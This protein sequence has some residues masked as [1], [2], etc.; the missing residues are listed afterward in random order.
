MSTQISEA[1][2]SRREANRDHQGKFGNDP[3]AETDLILG[4]LEEPTESDAGQE[5]EGFEYARI[6][7]LM[8]DAYHLDPERKVALP[9]INEDDTIAQVHHKLNRYLA[10]TQDVSDLD[11]E[12][13]AEMAGF[14]HAPDEEMPERLRNEFGISE[15]DR[16]VVAETGDGW[17]VYVSTGNTAKKTGSYYSR[18][19]RERFQV[20]NV[21]EVT[22]APKMQQEFADDHPDLASKEVKDLFRR[23]NGDY[24]GKGHR[25]MWNEDALSRRNYFA[26]SVARTQAGLSDTPMSDQ[27]LR[28]WV[29]SLPQAEDG[30]AVVA[31]PRGEA[32]MEAPRGIEGDLAGTSPHASSAATNT[33][34][35]R[36]ITE[37]LADEYDYTLQRKY[38][39]DNSGEGGARVF[40]QK[41]NVPQ[42]HLDAAEASTF[43]TT[44]DF[45]HVEVDADTDL[46]KLAHVGAEYEQLRKHLPKTGSTPTL[47]FRKTGRH[48]ALGV[49]HPHVDNIAVDPRSPSAMIHEYAH[50][51]DHTAGDRNLSS[52]EDFRAILRAA[53]REVS[54]SDDPALNKKR[55]YYRTPTEI[56]ARTF[57]CYFHWKGV[58]TSLNDGD[59]RLST[60]A[61]SR[62]T[63]DCKNVG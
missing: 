58:D 2:V 27:E 10:K 15:S 8:G 19:T 61:V 41:K 51:I 45:R 21:A 57:Q 26:L 37:K 31:G 59:E 55:D 13:L 63:Q 28:E 44:G 38:V 4:D 9:R 25:Y 42:S 43:A 35:R 11:D 56:H 46:D 29:A 24:R 50:H 60:E 36:W 48:Q 32:L 7:S 12:Q 22:T 6:S 18:L 33:A 39:N 14:H 1:A 62:C 54:A 47:R 52:E 5:S 16:V 20:V 23:L 40:E 3:A 30:R 17:P 53:Q 34:Y 49:Y